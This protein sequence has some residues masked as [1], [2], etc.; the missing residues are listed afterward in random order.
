MSIDSNKK[1]TL[2]ST[3]CP[4]NGGVSFC[5]ET[6][7]QLIC[8]NEKW[9]LNT[10]LLK[11][12]SRERRC[13]TCQRAFHCKLNISMSQLFKIGILPECINCNK[14]YIC[15]FVTCVERC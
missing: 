8:S 4:D 6:P 10:D 1:I 7:E 5:T 12:S 13:I 14:K 9:N 2:K 3:H 11:C 15:I